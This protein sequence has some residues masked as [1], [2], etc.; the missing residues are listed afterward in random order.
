MP[1]ETLLEAG[2]GVQ[3][4][5]LPTR[6]PPRGAAEANSATQKKMKIKKQKQRSAAPLSDNRCQRFP[7]KIGLATNALG[8]FC[9]A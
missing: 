5:A 2:V 7:A 6:P 8:Y 4:R 9:R 3:N 1:T